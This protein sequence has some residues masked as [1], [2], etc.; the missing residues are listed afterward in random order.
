MTL[1]AAISLVAV[2]LGC[3]IGANRLAAARGPARSPRLAITLWQALGLTAGMGV[4]CSQ[5]S[6]GIISMIAN[7]A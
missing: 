1:Y 5:P 3:V 7:V 6:S 2:A 4:V